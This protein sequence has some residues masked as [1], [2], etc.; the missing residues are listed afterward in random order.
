MDNVLVGVYVDVQFRAV[1]HQLLQR[2]TATAVHRDRAEAGTGGVHERGH[3]VAACAYSVLTE[4]LAVLGCLTG[5]HVQ[6]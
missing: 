1:L 5:A 6:R 3:R 2:E 4:L